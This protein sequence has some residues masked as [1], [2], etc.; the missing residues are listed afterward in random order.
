MVI[1]N[2]WHKGNK[3]FLF[4]AFTLAKVWRA[5]MLDTI[6]QHQHINLPAKYPKSGW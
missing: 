6:N 1:K 3:Q 2:Q 4:N 5:K